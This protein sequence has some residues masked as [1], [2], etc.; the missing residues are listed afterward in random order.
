MVENPDFTA[1]VD[2]SIA[3]NVKLARER[4]GL[5]QSELAARLTSMG[6]GGFHQTTVARIESGTRVLRLAEALAIARLLDYRVE[7]LVES[8]EST[9]LR[10]EYDSLSKGVE[11]FWSA[12][13]ELMRVRLLTAQSLD[14]KFPYGSHAHLTVNPS[15]F[16]MIDELL[17]TNSEPVDRVRT[18][19]MEWRNHVAQFVEPFKSSRVM[20]LYAEIITWAYSD[21]SLHL[22]DRTE[23]PTEV[24]DRE[25]LELFAEVQDEHQEAP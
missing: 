2:A 8:E 20:D 15:T 19:Y 18:M 10:W 11:A 17:S 13:Q 9:S 5:S 6:V 12:G 25:V 1:K 14:D 23:V 21:I 16:E 24:F 7:E 22:H 3:R 4:A